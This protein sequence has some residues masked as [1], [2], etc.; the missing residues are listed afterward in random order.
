MT[1]I[2]RGDEEWQ[3]AQILAGTVRICNVVFLFSVAV[4]VKESQ[5]FALS[6]I[7]MQ[8]MHFRSAVAL[9]SPCMFTLVLVSNCARSV[10]WFLPKS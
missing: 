1:E 8:S 10:K 7:A 2:E 3:K 5:S 6:S 9:K 4:V